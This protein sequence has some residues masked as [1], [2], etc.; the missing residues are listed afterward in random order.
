M[1]VLEHELKVNPFE[2]INSSKESQQE[3]Q[4]EKTIDAAVDE[5]RDVY[6]SLD[7]GYKIVEAITKLLL[8]TL[9]TVQINKFIH[10]LDKAEQNDAHLAF[11]IN[12]LVQDT[13]KAH[14]NEIQLLM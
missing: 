14:N 12:R 6:L 9:N 8:P 4:I 5:V 3:Q 13:Y 1:K 10:S 11:F 2:G 7:H